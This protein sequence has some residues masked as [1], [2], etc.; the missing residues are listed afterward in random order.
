MPTPPPEHAE[1]LACYM[2]DRRDKRL[3]TFG[4]LAAYTAAAAASLL[5][6]V[7]SKLVLDSLESLATVVVVAHI[8][9]G[10]AQRAVA[11]TAGNG[12]RPAK[13]ETTP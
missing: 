5:G 8:A 9:G 11:R 7:Q 2:T 1:R 13:P 3:I 12:E 4:V 10:V 6:A